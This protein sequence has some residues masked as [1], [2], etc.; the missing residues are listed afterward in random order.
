MVRMEGRRAGGQ[1]GRQGG[2]GSAWR[3]SWPAGWS[4]KR[5]QWRQWTGSEQAVASLVSRARRACIRRVAGDEALGVLEEGDVGRVDA[6][7]RGHLSRESTLL[8]S[9]SY[10]SPLKSEQRGPQT[11]KVQ[12]APGCRGGA[13]ARVTVH[14]HRCSALQTWY[15]HRGSMNN[16]A[17]QVFKYV[18]R[19]IPQLTLPPRAGIDL[20]ATR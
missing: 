5:C 15:G 14:Q 11:E 9:L 4:R 19:R 2:I 10:N 12:R 16:L 1:E 7:D 13:W 8:Y 6:E 3:V 20:I 18:S 17:N